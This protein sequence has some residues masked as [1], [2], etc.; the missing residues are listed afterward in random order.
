MDDN[1]IV[2]I[3]TASGKGSIGVIRL[4]GKKALPIVQT[5]CRAQFTPRHATLTSVFINPEQDERIDQ[6][7]VI[8]FKAPHS[9]TGEDVVEIQGHGGPV[10]L[11]AI[12]TACIAEGARLAL[13]GEFSQRAFLNDKIDL[14]QAEAIADLINSASLQAAQSAMRSLTGVFSHKIN[15]LVEQVIALRVFVEASIDFPEEEIDFL[16]DSYISTQLAALI[17]QLK[18]I[19]S[20][21]KQGCVMQEGLNVVLAGKPNA[22][23]SSLLNALAGYEAAIVTPIA[24]T[25][26]DIVKEQITIG[27]MPIHITDTAGIRNSDDLIEQEGIKRAE[28]AIQQADI[29]LLVIDSQDIVDKATLWPSFLDENDHRITIIFNKIDLIEKA[30]INSMG[31]QTTLFLSAKT[32]L[33]ID[34][35]HQHIKKIAGIQQVEGNF[36]ARRRHID[37]LEKSLTFILAGENQLKTAAAGELLAEDLRQCQQQLNQIT[38]EFNADDLLGE[39]FSSF[40]IGK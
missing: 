37:S 34:L 25:T 36:S 39:I 31:Q 29:I 13:P 32:E 3:A 22:G 23:K 35:L 26:R 20:T 14:I 28:K 27:G 38:G 5:I 24:G 10:I 19:L 21:A 33:G 4:S 18:L 30:K 9:F 40:C 17:E 11:D 6:A 12:T 16:E 8:Y 2:A 15:T 7:I 1:T